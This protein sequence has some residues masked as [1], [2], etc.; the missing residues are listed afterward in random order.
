M[1]IF[2][3]ASGKRIHTITYISDQTSQLWFTSGQMNQYRTNLTKNRVR[4]LFILLGI[5]AAIICEVMRIQIN[6]SCGT[7]VTFFSSSPSLPS[8]LSTATNFIENFLFFT[9]HLEL[10]LVAV[11][12]FCSGMYPLGWKRNMIYT[13]VMQCSCMFLSSLDPEN[14]SMNWNSGCD[15]CAFS[16]QHI[17][18][19][20]VPRTNEQTRSAT[21]TNVYNLHTSYMYKNKYTNVSWQELCPRFMPLNGSFYLTTHYLIYLKSQFEYDL[22]TPP[23][24]TTMLCRC[25]QQL[26]L[27]V[28]GLFG[29]LN[30][31]HGAQWP[32]KLETYLFWTCFEA[33]PLRS[34]QY[35]K[36]WTHFPFFPYLCLESDINTP[37]AHIRFSVSD[38]SQV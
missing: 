22:S 28:C 2:I 12:P 1:F 31:C 29:S 34:H 37:S 30:E 19:L 4:P 18:W 8:Q 6:S 11:S 17:L 32:R 16:H 3:S 10:S 38:C 36:I 13:P 20:A 33:D 27:L 21:A 25:Q 24:S 14:V 35:S 15:I 9:S 23:H 26:V 7:S 5:F